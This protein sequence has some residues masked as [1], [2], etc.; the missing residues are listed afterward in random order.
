MKPAIAELLRWF[1]GERVRR[2]PASTQ[3]AAAEPNLSTA[4]RRASAA[5]LD[6]LFAAGLGPMLRDALG[7][8]TESL[9][10]HVGER[11]LAAD[12]TARVLIEQR[13]A[14]ARDVIDASLGCG[15]PITL[16]KGIS[17]SQYEYERAHFRPMTDVDVL[18]SEKAVPALEQ[19]LLAQGYWRDAPIMHEG[20]Q[21]AEPLYHP[22]SG[23]RVELHVRLF[24]VRSPLQTGRVFAP[25]TLERE[26]IDAA[27]H[28]LSVRR[29]SPELQLVYLASAWN[30]DLCGQPVDP[31]FV[32]GLFD[33]VALTRPPFDWDRMFGL[34]DNPTAAA[35]VDVLLN[36]LA[37]SGALAVP[38][39][40]LATVRR[41][42]RLMGAAEVAI[43]TSLVNGYLLRGRRF[44]LCNSWRIWSGLF[45]D[46]DRPVLK[47]AML[48]W[49]V[50]FPPGDPDRFSFGPQWRRLQRWASKI[51][52]SQR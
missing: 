1:S 33:A 2:E 31:S 38:M 3:P 23:T 41:R 13:V 49:Y 22:V 43:L 39:H 25:A 18:V 4:I 26:S 32:F 35:S 47:V 30:R 24:P 15:E 45:A 11:L 21:H 42:H 16:L 48:P 19:A 8:A 17:L 29:L 9:P 5:E 51:P 6:W 20:S 7:M 12:L 46:E 10:A 40:V 50:A 28:G 34:I 27:F 14:A 36:C 44:T 37:S 52:S